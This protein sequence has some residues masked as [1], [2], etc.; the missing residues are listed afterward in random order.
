MTSNSHRSIFYKILT[1]VRRTMVV[2][3]DRLPW[4]YILAVMVFGLMG[5]LVL[6]L[7]SEIDEGDARAIDRAILLA[8]RNP[9]D[10]T[11][12]I[13]PGWI[14][15]VTKD[16]TTLGSPAVLVLAVFGA[17]G[18]MVAR[19]S[20]RMAAI[21]IAASAS[22]SLVVVL[23]KGVF[24]RA[25]P[26]VVTRL[27]EETSMSFPSGH[28]ANSAIIY[29]TIAVLFVRVEQSLRTRIFALALGI[30]VVLSIGISRLAL[31][32]HWPTDVVA[33]WL[34]G[35]VWASIWAM[36]VKL[37]TIDSAVDLSAISEG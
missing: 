13:G 19:R 7:W 26:D 9:A 2:A 12:L 16:I 20:Y 25:R 30:L 18:F 8:F 10:T 31:G 36:V 33:G 22:G 24:D 32:V 29:L 23:L 28:A 3:E 15:Q 6:E 11:S 17:A 37:P 4:R 35:A 21:V 34:I 5:F 27:V 1:V 14:E